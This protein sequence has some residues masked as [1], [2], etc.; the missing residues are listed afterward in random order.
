LYGRT[1]AWEKKHN[2]AIPAFAEVIRRDP[3]LEDAY[4]AWIDAE[5]WAGKKDSALLFSRKALNALPTSRTI[6]EKKAKLLA[7]R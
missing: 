7:V 2:L 1:Y 4:C 5:S 6:R 3:R